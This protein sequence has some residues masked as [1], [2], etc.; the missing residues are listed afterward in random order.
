M[1]LTKI[2]THN[3]FFEYSLDLITIIG[4]KGE[5]IKINGA[6]T[7]TLGWAFGDLQDKKFIDYVHPDDVDIT[8]TALLELFQSKKISSFINKYK[9]KNGSYLWLEWNSVLAENGL[10]YVIARDVSDR[11]IADRKIREQQKL[12]E[13]AE[14]MAKLGHWKFN[15]ET[16]GIYWSRQTSIIHGLDPDMYKP[17]L[18]E[19]I[20]FY[21]QDDRSRVNTI[22]QQ[23]IERKEPF[24]FEAR[25]IRPDGQERV[26]ESYGY[27]EIDEHGLAISVFGTFHDVTERKLVEIERKIYLENLQRALD[28]AEAATRIKSDFVANITHEIRTPLGAMIGAAELISKT[29]LTDKQER[30]VQLVREA[31]I[32][33]LDM[34]NDVLDFS[35]IEQG[36]MSVKAERV[37]ILDLSRSVYDL[38]IKQAQDKNL[39]YDF[40]YSPEIPDYLYAD[41]IKIRQVL[42]N[43]L[44]NAIKYTAQG[45]VLLQLDC[46]KNTEEEITLRWTISDTG[47]GIPHDRQQYIFDKFFQIGDSRSHNHVGTGLGLNISRSLISLMGGDIGFSSTPEE[48]S[49]FWF[50][51]DMSKEEIMTASRTEQYEIE[52][53]QFSG[54]AL[55]VDDV[56][57]NRFIA[58]ELLINAGLRVD[59]AE[60][61]PEA[62]SKCSQEKYDLIFLD[63]RMSGMDGYEVLSK[64][65]ELD[66]YNQGKAVIIAYT[67]Q[68]SQNDLP[69]FLEHGFDDL[70]VKPITEIAVLKILNEYL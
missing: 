9:C 37:H 49:A 64:I 2:N 61:G 30:Y 69:K 50:S 20:L 53:H 3:D 15:L 18:E 57:F 48:G 54:Q 34:V 66:Y 11:V 35:K 8:K 17:N 62:L 56:E 41:P 12:L 58:S 21:H 27:I 52:A 36:M 31:G 43:L 45:R 40:L 42:N 55:V 4:L 26:I 5:F 14:N 47:Y 39:S 13:M 7:N 16:E 25:L 33:L 59:L 29:T 38:F 6:W 60:N 44:S 22:L 46:L 65:L 68:G 51:L 24:I 70:L 1:D 63:L 32:S 23:A 28:E 10:Y 67:A 19:A